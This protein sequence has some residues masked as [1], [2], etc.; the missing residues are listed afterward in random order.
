MRRRRASGVGVHRFQRPSRAA[1]AGTSRVRTITASRMTPTAS[2]V[3]GTSTAMSL[4]VLSDAK[5]IARM[6]AADVM[7]RPVRPIALTIA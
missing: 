3:A 7:S 1:K 2:P 6:S 4:T 5:E